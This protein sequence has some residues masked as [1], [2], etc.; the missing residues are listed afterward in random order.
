MLHRTPSFSKKGSGTQPASAEV[1][2]FL[3]G[4]VMTGR[5]VDQIL[6]HPGD[7]RLKEPYVENA[8][9]Y[10]ALA[11]RVNGPIPRPVDF[12]W[13]WGDAL[14][15]LD[16]VAPDAR[17]INLE[18]SITRSNRYWR[19]KTIHYR[20]H[21]ENIAC[22]TAARIDACALANNHVLDFGYSGL[23]ETLEV[24]RRAGI[25]TAGAGRS[26]DEARRPAIVDLGSRGRVLLFSFGDESS[27]IEPSWA[28]TRHRPG[29]DFLVDLSEATAADVQQRIG[30]TKR[31]GD[32]V[33]ASIHWGS[34]WGYD[35]SRDQM[36]FAHL[37]IDGGVDIVH[38]H[39]SHHPRPIECY[40]NKLILYGCGDFVNDYE[41]ISGYEAY[42]DDLTV[43]YFPSVASNT[44][45]LLALRMTPMQIRTM[46]LQRPS[47]QDVLWLGTVL[48]K[49]SRPFGTQVVIEPDQAFSLRW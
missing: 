16:R 44:G 40:R 27:G 45:E 13:I 12:S 35:V 9:E 25:R 32:I 43:M 7:P 4:D 42:R 3:C 29:V 20:M 26:A 37:L 41:G 36:R 8:R 18:T 15:E 5:G 33:V 39:S 30:R 17:V 2:L 46:R 11:E 22:L 48:D 38:G 1:T 28:A 49:V 6:P 21:P 24:L 19:G 23:L 47:Q 10:V 31:S 34:N 14:G